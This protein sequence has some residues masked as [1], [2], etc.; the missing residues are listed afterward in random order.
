MRNTCIGDKLI[1]PGTSGIMNYP[2]GNTRKVDAVQQRKNS[3]IPNE[4]GKYTVNTLT[5][6]IFKDQSETKSEERDHSTHPWIICN[7][8]LMKLSTYLTLPLTT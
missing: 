8:T 2:Q 6:E 5:A 3:A 4:K 1:D 7:L